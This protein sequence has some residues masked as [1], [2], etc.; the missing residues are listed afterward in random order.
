MK[1]KRIDIIMKEIE[2]SFDITMAQLLI[3]YI[4]KHPDIKNPENRVTIKK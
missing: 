4:N 3:N 2:K 1:E